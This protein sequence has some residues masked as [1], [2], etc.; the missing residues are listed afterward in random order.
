MQCFCHII[1]WLMREKQF[2]ETDSPA[3]LARALGDKY[4][5]DTFK[6]YI[7]K[8]NIV[9]TAQSVFELESIINH[10]KS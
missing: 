8:T 2:F 10:Y 1:G 3:E 9:L 4:S 6:D 7:K 5:K